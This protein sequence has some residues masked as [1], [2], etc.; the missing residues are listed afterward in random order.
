MGSFRRGSLL[1]SLKLGIAFFAVIA[2]SIGTAS[3]AAAATARYGP[4]ASTSP[5]S[6]T[7][8]P[9]WAL[10]AFRRVFTV[11]TTPTAANTYRVREDFNHGS[12]VTIGGK[13]PGACTT[14]TYNGGTVLAGVT[15]R[16]GGY[17]DGTV[18]GGTYNAAAVCTPA[19]CGTT[20]GFIATV[21]GPTATYNVTTFIFTYIT[22]CNGTW[23]N[24]SAD[25][26]GNRGDITG[27]PHTCG[28]GD[29]GDQGNH[30]DGDQGDHDN[31][32]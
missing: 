1:R 28:G 2:F 29:D 10:D 23:I 21:F 13:S 31:S 26:G 32:D 4:F 5:D 6:G 19:N 30:D 17:F 24:A 25:L 22:R 14:G 3:P 18:T 9:D 12:F 8:G 7:C 11:N 15:G 27:A 16:M 20:A